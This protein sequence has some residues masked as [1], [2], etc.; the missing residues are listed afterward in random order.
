MRAHPGVIALLLAGALCSPTGAAAQAAPSEVIAISP[1]DSD[2]QILEKA[3][4]VVPSERQQTWQR[5]ELTSFHHFGPNT[6]TGRE[7]GTGTEDPDVFN[8]AQL[9]TDQWMR[10]LRDT[11][12]KQAILTVKHHD[13]FLLYP[14]RYSNHSVKESEWQNGDGNVVRSFVDSAKKYGLKVGF[15]LSPADLHEAQPGGRFG[16]GS[17][18]VDT[19]IP[20]PGLDGT[21]PDGPRFNVRANDYNRFYLNTLYELLTEYGTIDEVWWD[22]ADA[23]GGGKESF[24]YADWI[25]MVR[26]LQ[27]DAVIF[28]DGGP[29]VRWVGNESGYGRVTEHSVLPFNGP[30]DPDR[31]VKPDDNGAGDLGSNG[32]LTQRNSNGTPRWDY[33]KWLPAECDTHLGPGWFWH[34]NQQP[35]SLSWLQDVYFGSVG[36]NCQLL[37]NIA[38]DN[39]G[40]LPGD[41]VDRLHEF[42]RW[43]SDVFGADHARGARATNDSGTTNTPGNTPAKAVDGDAS[44]SW[45]PTGK[46][47]SLVVDFGAA[48]KVSVIGVQENLGVGQRVTSFAVDSWNGSGWQQV[49]TGT[50]IGHKRLL[51]LTRPVTTDKLRLRVTGARGR[52]AIATVSAHQDGQPSNLALGKPARQSTTHHLGAAAGRAVDGNTDGSFWGN[53]VTH[54]SDTEPDPRPWWQVDLGSS[55]QIGTVTVHNRTDCCGDRL[56]DYWVFVSDRPFDTTKSPEQQAGTPGVWSTHQTSQAGSPTRLPVG[57]NGRYVMVQQ[58]GAVVLSLAEVE[59]FATQ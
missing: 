30:A 14:T 5:M 40:R 9:D 10:T 43:R 18:S 7:W 8:P 20:E 33:V 50:T 23:V 27:P 4:N 59:V 28:Q 19:V 2:E 53:S 34:Q 37:L 42:A 1:G 12:F 49:S 31:L 32:L 51:E 54:T 29:D 44:T 24:V 47:G 26:T 21:R 35:N 11:G 46:T 16:N 56:S 22:G 13:G 36:R 58:S 39:T 3:G 52:P 6:F 41:D 15:Y 57:R 25:R 55:Q 48:R 45:Q 17:R 38:P